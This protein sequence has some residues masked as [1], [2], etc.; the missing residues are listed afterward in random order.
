MNTLCWVRESA[1]GNKFVLLDFAP[2]LRNR[3]RAA[4]PLV[5]LEEYTASEFPLGLLPFVG[6]RSSSVGK[7]SR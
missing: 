2:E 7:Y 1:S 4:P 3:V 6:F 5:Q